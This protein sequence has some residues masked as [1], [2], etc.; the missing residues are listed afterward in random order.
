MSLL[1]PSGP[2]KSERKLICPSELVCV[3]PCMSLSLQKI[4]R[5]DI[6]DKFLQLLAS[7]AV[8]IHSIKQ[9]GMVP[10]TPRA[11]FV[12]THTCNLIES[13]PTKFVMCAGFYRVPAHGTH[14]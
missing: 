10:A 8:A 6:L 7:L 2:W 1:G 5:C 11:I 13:I 9:S 3:S 4:V 12:N 14:F